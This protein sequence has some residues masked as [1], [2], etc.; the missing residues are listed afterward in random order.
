MQNVREEV[1]VGT[2]T[3][4]K[5]PVQELICQY[6]KHKAVDVVLHSFGEH[7]IDGGDQDTSVEEG[8]NDREEDESQWSGL[9]AADGCMAASGEGLRNESL[10]SAKGKVSSEVAEE[11]A[12]SAAEATEYHRSLVLLDTLSQA[13]S[14]L[15]QVGDFSAANMLDNHARGEKRRQRAK[16]TGNAAVAAPLARHADA[17]MQKECAARRAAAAALNRKRETAQDL[18]KQLTDAKRELKK[19]KEG[20]AEV[21]KVSACKHSLKTFSLEQLG[22]GSDSGG[23]AAGRKKRAEVLDRLATLGDRPVCRPAE[24]LGLVQG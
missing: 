17:E 8:S 20:I 14:S 2:L 1:A 15:R 12:M 7:T 5:Q 13:A 22:Q 18:Q 11:R 4:T 6:P 23:A 19:K 10:V 24:R 3:W 9:D 16:A 21:E